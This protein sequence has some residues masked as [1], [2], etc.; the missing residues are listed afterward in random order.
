MNET[1]ITSTSTPTGTPEVDV[2]VANAFMITLTDPRCPYC[3]E[4]AHVGRHCNP[5][6]VCDKRPAT[7]DTRPG[8]D[9]GCDWHA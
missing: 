5:V 9:P 1:K 3:A 6:T 8:T 7:C 2:A 4:P